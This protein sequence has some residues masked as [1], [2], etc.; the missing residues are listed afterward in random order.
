MPSMRPL[1]FAARSP[2]NSHAGIMKLY[3]RMSAP[4][5]KSCA[6]FSFPYGSPENFLRS[7]GKKEKE[8]KK[9]RKGKN[10]FFSAFLK[11]HRRFLTC[12]ILLT[13]KSCPCALNVRHGVQ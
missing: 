12:H 5:W 3:R 10:A 2:L 11:K 7:T 13:L 8:K 4:A 9:K 1:T 6:T